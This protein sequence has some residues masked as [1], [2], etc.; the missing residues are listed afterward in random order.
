METGIIYECIQGEKY[1]A[2]KCLHS[3]V[4]RRGGFVIFT[5]HENRVFDLSY[6]AL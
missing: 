5:M 6:T 1:K 4:I 2:A 3:P